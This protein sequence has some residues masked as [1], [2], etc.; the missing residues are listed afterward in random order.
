MTASDIARSLGGR[1]SGAGWMARCPAHKDRSPSLSLRDADGR[2]LIYCFSGCEQARVIAALRERGLWPERERPALTPVQRRD[3]A[4]ARREA[5][6]IA[7]AALWWW[8]ARLSELEDFKREAI[9][10]D[11][12]DID[13]LAPA[14]NALY[15]LQN[16]APDAIV[17][18][19]LHA[20]ATDPH[21][22]RQ[23]VRIGATWERACRAVVLACLTKPG[24]EVSRAA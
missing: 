7:R 19:Y 14:A 6:P 10:S 18:H 17:Q 9:G 1:K 5:K 4:K 21:G 24:A 13:K 11:G 12:V 8:Q 15:R 16:L 3:Y 2:V 23:L 22:T 20:R